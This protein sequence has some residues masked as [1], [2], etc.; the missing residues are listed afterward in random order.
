[1][2]NEA[3]KRRISVELERLKAIK[4]QEEG[5]KLKIELSRKQRQEKFLE[6][7]RCAREKQKV[8]VSC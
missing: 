3:E 7:K 8:C 4:K 2:E 6:A 5:K 1:M